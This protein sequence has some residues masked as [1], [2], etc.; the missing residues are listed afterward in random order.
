MGKTVKIGYLRRCRRGSYKGT[1]GILGEVYRKGISRYYNEWRVDQYTLVPFEIIFFGWSATVC[2]YHLL[3][4]V[5]T[6]IHPRNNDKTWAKNQIYLQTKVNMS[7]RIITQ[8]EA[9]QFVHI[10]TMHSVQFAMFLILS[11]GKKGNSTSTTIY[12]PRH[13]FYTN[14]FTRVNNSIQTLFWDITSPNLRKSWASEVLMD[15]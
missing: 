3:L 1:F 8:H 15:E 14:G 11:H 9:L 2:M 7:T 10:N 6:R 13:S 5:Q 4:I 12:L